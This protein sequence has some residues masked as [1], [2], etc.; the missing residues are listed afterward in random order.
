MRFFCQALVSQQQG[1]HLLH[2]EVIASLGLYGGPR[3]AACDKLLLEPEK[4]KGFCLLAEPVHV[5]A[6]KQAGQLVQHWA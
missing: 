4:I 2:P 1:G 3:P 5:H 6:C